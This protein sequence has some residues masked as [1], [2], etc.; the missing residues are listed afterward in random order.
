[1]DKSLAKISHKYEFLRLELEEN[2]EQLDE[3]LD[4]WNSIIGK[5]LMDKQKVMW[6]D[7]ETGEIREEQ[8][9]KE[10]KP[11]ADPR[12][13]KLYK[14]L[15]KHAHPDKGGTVDDFNELKKAYEE[16][17]VIE[18]IKFAV[19]YNVKVKLV[20][21]DSKLIEARINSL[22]NKINTIHQSLVW[23][24]FNGDIPTKQAVINEL[25]KVHQIKLSE[26]DIGTFLA[27]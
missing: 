27:F 19:K 1:M 23:T 14:R 3:Y 18:L 26:K 2:Q 11:E 13:R 25:E 4:K 24:Y 7:E 20:E 12:L 21:S 8:P 6:I 15:S 22:S 9:D 17:D 16:R 10:S 5:Y